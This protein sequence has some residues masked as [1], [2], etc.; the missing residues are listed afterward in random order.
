MSSRVR[1]LVPLLFLLSC[2]PAWWSVA[3]EDAARLAMSEG[4]YRSAATMLAG[5]AA[6]AA[7]DPIRGPHLRYLQGRSL[8]LAGDHRGSIR[9][10]EQLI[11]DFPDSAWV[12]KARFCVADSQASLGDTAGAAEAYREGTAELL[13]R[14]RRDEIAAIFQQYAHAAFAPDEERAAPDYATAQVLFATVLELDPSDTLRHDAEHHGAVCR[15][16]QG[17]AYEAARIL[18]GR[19]DEPDDP[20]AAEDRYQLARAQAR[21]DVDD[22]LRQYHLL[23]SLHPDH[24]LA[25]DALWEAATLLAPAQAPESVDPV[26]AVADLRRLVADHPD[27][28][29]AEEAHL[30]VA[31][32]LAAAGQREDAGAAY[33]EFIDAPERAA[34]ELRPEAMVELGHLL[35][36]AGDEGGEAMLRRFSAEYPNHPEWPGVQRHLTGADLRMGTDLYLAGDL[37][38]AVEA[39]TRHADA[40]PTE[41]AEARYLIGLARHQQGRTDEAVAQFEAVASKFARQ[42]IGGRAGYALARIALEDRRDPVAARDYL[43]RCVEGS[44]PDA[45]CYTLGSQLET[46][47]LDL[48][49]DRPLRTDEPAQVWLRARNL[50]EIELTLHRIDPEI[51]VRKEGSV[52]AMHGLD[53][54]LIEPD[55]RWSVPVEDA[56]DGLEW[57]GPVALRSAGAG[58]YVVAATGE[59]VRAQVPVVISDITLAVHRHLGDLLVYAQHRRTGLPVAGATVLISDGTSIVAEGQTDR[60]GLYHRVGPPAGEPLPYH[61]AVVALKGASMA[62]ATADGES[63][64][65]PDDL[66]L[67]ETVYTDRPAYRPGDTVAYRAVMRRL[68]DR[69]LDTLAGTPATVSLVSP[70]GWTVAEHETRL[71]EFG[72]LHGTFP[73]EVDPSAAT[74]PTGSYRVVVDLERGGQGSVGFQVT[75]AAPSRRHIE[76]EFDRD[77]YVIGDTARVTLRASTYTGEPVVGARIHVTWGHLDE[78]VLAEPTDEK[79]E[80]TVVAETLNRGGLGY[81]SL[82]AHLDGEPVEARGR[83]PV[84]ES[85]VALDLDLDRAVIRAGEALRFTLEASTDDQGVSGLPLR[86]RLIHLDR[87]GDAPAEPGNP[88]ATALWDEPFER[89]LAHPTPPRP[90]PARTAELTTGGDGQVTHA[91]ELTAPGRYQVLI[92][93]RDG[94]DRAIRALGEVQVIGAEGPVAGLALLPERS[95]LSAGDPARIQ[96]VGADPGPVVAVVQ[97]DGIASATVVR[98]RGD[99]DALELPLD[100]SLAPRARVAAIAL[101]GG[102]T[103]SGHADLRVRAALEV[104]VDGLDATPL[105][106]ETV[107]LTLRVRDEAD[108]P[109]DAQVSVAV[110]AS[111]LLAQFPERRR[112]AKGLFLP[113]DHELWGFTEAAVRFRAEGHGAA[114]DA[115]ILAELERLRARE[116]GPAVAL[117]PDDIDLMGDAEEVYWLEG[118]QFGMGGL[119]TR[120]SGSGGG[121]YGYGS[122]SL[123]GVVGGASGYGHGGRGQQITRFRAEAALW[124]GDLRTGSDGE[125]VVDLPLPGHSAAWTVVAVA[126]DRGRRSGEAKG[127]IVA[128]APAAAAVEPPRFVRLGDSPGLAGEV[129]A[130]AAGIYRLDGAIGA[131]QI[132]GPDRDLPGRRPVPLY[133]AGHP[134]GTADLQRTTDGTLGVPF[135]LA[136]AGDGGSSSETLAA[137]LAVADL[138]LERWS[139]GR[140]DRPLELTLPAPDGSVGE[141]QLV[142]ELAPATLPGALAQAMQPTFVCSGSAY[143]HANLA[144]AATALLD[145][146]AGRLSADQEALVRGLA[147]RHLVALVG[148]GPNA[149]PQWHRYPHNYGG[150]VAARGYVALVRGLRLGLLPP[151]AESS[152]RQRAD[153][154]R[155]A[156]LQ[157]LRSDS[158]THRESQFL[159]ALSIEAGDEATWS[160]A[161]TRLLRAADDPG[162]RGKLAVAAVDFGAREE[163]LHLRGELEADVETALAGGDRASLAAAAEGLAALEPGHPALDRASIALE[164]RLDDTWLSPATVAELGGALARLGGA[165]GGGFPAAVDVELP[166]GSRQRVDLSAGGAPRIAALVPAGEEAVISLEPVGRGGIRYRA[167]LI[168][169]GDGVRPDDPR[170]AITR[171]YRRQSIRLQGVDLPQGF[172]SLTGRYQPWSDALVELPV[173]RRSQVS[174]EV[175]YGRDAGRDPEGSVWVLEEMLPGGATLVD[176]SASGGLHVEPRG[177]RLVAYLDA[178]RRCTT[179]TYELEGRT[180]GEY[181]APGAR[182]RGLDDGVVFEVGEDARM[183]VIP[184]PGTAEIAA[185]DLELPAEPFRATPDEL[186]ALGLAQADLERWEE[187]VATLEE[188]LSM[189]TVEPR[190][191]GEVAARLLHGAVLLGDGEGTLRAFELLKERDPSYPIPFD[192]IVAVARAYEDAGEPHRALRVYRTTLAAR[193]LNEARMG[194]VLESENLLLPSLR[195]GADLTRAYPDLAAVQSS[196]FHL[197]QIWADRAGDA[198]YDPALRARGIDRDTML[199]TSADWMLEF[200]ARYPDSPLAEEA[201][202]HLA[203]TYLEL[204]DS[205]RAARV[206]RAASRRYSDGAY[207]D[208]FLYM[209]GHAHRA[210]GRMGPALLLLDRVATGAFVPAGGGAPGP[211]E[212]RPLALYSIAQIHDAEGRGDRALEYYGKVADRYRDAGEAVAQMEAVVLESEEVR[213]VSTGQ[214]PAVELTVRNVDQADL[215]LYR[216]DLMRLYLR[217]KSLSN[218]TGVRLA[219]IEPTCRRELPLGARFREQQVS[220]SLPLSQPGAY[221][222]LVKGAGLEVGSLL[223][224]SDLTL[225]VQEDRNLGRVR[226]TVT[227]PAGQPVADAH[228]KVIGTS[229]GAIVSGDTDLRGVFVAEAVHGVPTVIARHDEHYAFHRGAQQ[230]PPPPAVRMPSASVQEVDLLE[231]L[232]SLGY[233]Q[234]QENRAA[235]DKDVYGAEFQGVSAEQLE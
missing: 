40:N 156:L 108:R 205:A 11:D 78:P 154:A 101:R 109:V 79:G 182:L 18:A 41:D 160:P 89:G 141:R 67:V 224:Y 127:E 151:E 229:G 63:R 149:A 6:R 3:D 152:A 235:F 155:S 117:R 219:G 131:T 112:R 61:C 222:A 225:A 215:L 86:A 143:T 221:L 5:E 23:V 196:L 130:D 190:R 178:S 166:D 12:R 80:T 207:L 175:C 132:S 223:L 43:K 84:R 72:A 194:R 133:L 87:P 113:D 57:R 220:V 64:D 85:E 70:R 34:S 231:Q 170:L 38:G 62:T 58:V 214:D 21:Q 82:V 167:G 2:I 97:A 144:Y 162:T 138:P 44:S 71:D 212:Q 90:E 184:P 28:E 176:G 193:F 36:A 159:R 218:V 106:G 42:P 206:G 13:D 153:A 204:D 121:G 107:P 77:V 227:D 91:W 186:Y 10:F 24:P 188:L 136:M 203:G 54:E 116:E 213:T 39:L 201:A 165:A 179:L 95:S 51:L 226:V 234:R 103:L 93:G 14:D 111:S 88:F 98:W 230:A 47:G 198:E 210:A 195:F 150:T 211:S 104:S 52:E 142:V 187:A 122:G 137:R 53:V 65:L 8:Q 114:I 115:A 158:P 59:T 81:L 171:H 199:A 192:E 233:V 202:F 119:G 123:G 174:V 29:H 30:R 46:E 99:G 73:L 180:P 135:R 161:L 74:D 35:E 232:R 169:R 76:V 183:T 27:H 56:T 173:G 60:T 92:S 126:V 37:D 177:D 45:G 125:V 32:V 140:L 49:S 110:V 102:R 148:D 26:W 181:G 147:S 96:L 4:S 17:Q 69:R 105:P 68:A 145:G 189:G 164:A 25:G 15:L 118:E 124:I 172:A 9:A 75:E 200:A 209:Q 163:A 22:A 55:A 228:V 128:R 48:Y 168:G 197:P 191:G 7:D 146:P 16:E 50:E 157:A 139:A 185:G 120:G 100:P 134:L 31:R 94:R 33:R 216:V 217:E 20:L 129:R 208:S 1:R 66:P 19:L 83:V